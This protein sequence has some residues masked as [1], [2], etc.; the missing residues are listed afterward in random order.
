MGVRKLDSIMRRKTAI[1]K[2]EKATNNEIEQTLT[3]TCLS[4]LSIRGIEEICE[5]KWLTLLG[6]EVWGRP[7]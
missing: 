4:L 5:G 2:Q 1:K 7:S 3:V 6:V